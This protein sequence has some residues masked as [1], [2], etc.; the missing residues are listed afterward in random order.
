MQNIIYDSD[1][2]PQALKEKIEQWL[3]EKYFQEK[4]ESENDLQFFYRLRKNALGPF[5]KKIWDIPQKNINKIC[6]QLETKFI[7]FFQKLN[8]SDTKDLIKKLYKI[9][10]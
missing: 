1:Y 7:F 9:S 8:V 10:N 2:F 3:K 4:K 5:K 6:E